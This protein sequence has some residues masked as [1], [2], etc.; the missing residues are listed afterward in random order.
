MRVGK[1]IINLPL[2]GY[3]PLRPGLLGGDKLDVSVA[4]VGSG[5]W[6]HKLHRS[7]LSSVNRAS[8]HVV[9]RGNWF[10]NLS[11]LDGGN[12]FGNDVHFG[13]RT[14]LR[15]G[16]GLIFAALLLLASTAAAQ[17]A[18]AKECANQKDEASRQ[19]ND[20]DGRDS[21]DMLWLLMVVVF[22]LVRILPIPFWL[23]FFDKNWGQIQSQMPLPVIMF[24]I[25]G[26]ILLVSLNCYW[27]YLIVYGL[28]K[29][30]KNEGPRGAEE[31]DV[32]VE[33]GKS[34]QENEPLA[35]EK[36]PEN[37]ESIDAPPKQPSTDGSTNSA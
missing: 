12:L 34:V 13:R 17:A 30:I 11:V 35:K 20:G 2:V 36:Q 9:E 28:I 16:N 37:Y 1:V 19:A 14:S 24:I 7:I 23:W 32:D 31:H 18:A 22:F 29:L 33:R 26:F 25:V 4:R 21:R 27:F 3:T 8:G 10:R 15:N 5:R 6:G